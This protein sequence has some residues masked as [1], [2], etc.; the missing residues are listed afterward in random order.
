[1]KRINPRDRRGVLVRLSARGATAVRQVAPFVRRVNDLLFENV[2]RKDFATIA[3]FLRAFARNSEH[4]LGEIR[5]SER[6]RA[7]RK[8]R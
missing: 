5:R 4:A 6:A 3:R 7:T 2:R 8:P 1:V